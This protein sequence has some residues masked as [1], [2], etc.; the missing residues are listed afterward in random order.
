MQ[1]TQD[2]QWTFSKRGEPLRNTICDDFCEF[3]FTPQFKD[4]FLIDGNFK[5]EQAEH[6]YGNAKEYIFSAAF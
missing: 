6:F 2:Q 4:H 1:N 5:V 3:F